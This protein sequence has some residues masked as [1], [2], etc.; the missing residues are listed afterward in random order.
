MFRAASEPSRGE[1][2]PILDISTNIMHVS[3]KSV[4]ELLFDC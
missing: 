3:E 2:F 4:E 1:M